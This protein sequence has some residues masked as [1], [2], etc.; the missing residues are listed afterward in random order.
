VNVVVAGWRG[1]LP[2]VRGF[3]FRIRGVDLDAGGEEVA[4]ELPAEALLLSE[5]SFLDFVLLGQVGFLDRIEEFSIR[6]RERF[7]EIMVGG[8][9]PA[10][11]SAAHRP[12]PRVRER[13]PRYRRRRR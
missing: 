1:R 6:Q 3:I 2:L 11:E 5:P 9:E 7:F 8:A 4:V 13:T 12:E 10:D